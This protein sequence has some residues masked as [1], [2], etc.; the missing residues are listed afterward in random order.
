MASLVL[1]LLVTATTML[2]VRGREGKYYCAAHKDGSNDSPKHWWNDE[3]TTFPVTI[4]WYCCNTEHAYPSVK[5]ACNNSKRYKKLYGSC[6]RLVVISGSD[7]GSGY[8]DCCDKWNDDHDCSS[9]RLDE[10]DL[11]QT[12]QSN[13]TASDSRS[14]VS[15]APQVQSEL[16]QERVFAHLNTSDSLPSA[17]ARAILV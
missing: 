7:D 9:R 4:N 8:A 12:L 13:T 10:Q 2:E 16:M 17:A 6:R 5:E 14:W 15:N 3:G 11:E 1:F